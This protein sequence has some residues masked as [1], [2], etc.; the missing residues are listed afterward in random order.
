MVFPLGILDRPGLG[1]PDNYTMISSW[2][3]MSKPDLILPP[4]PPNIKTY[5]KKCLDLPASKIIKKTISPNLLEC[6]L[7]NLSSTKLHCPIEGKLLKQYVHTA[8]HKWTHRQK[9]IA[10]VALNNILTGTQ[11]TLTRQLPALHCRNAE[12]ALRNGELMTDA[13]ASWVTNK[14]VAGPF[15]NPLLPNF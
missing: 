13:V 14:F 9:T 15:K 12:S 7:K 4:P 6:I 11:T 1:L 8:Q 3:I 5:C 2:W 10:H